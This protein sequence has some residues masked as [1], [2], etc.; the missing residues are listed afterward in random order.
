MAE[1]QDQVKSLKPFKGILVSHEARY[2]NTAPNSRDLVI[3]EIA[4]AI[5]EAAAEKGKKVPEDEVLYK[6][7]AKT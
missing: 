7:S 1:N 6:V 5:C 3:D 4:T 2:R